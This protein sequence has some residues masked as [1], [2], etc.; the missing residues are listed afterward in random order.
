MIQAIILSVMPLLD[1]MGTPAPIPMLVPMGTPAPMPS[2][3]GQGRPNEDLPTVGFDTL[4]HTMTFRSTA[5][6][7]YTCAIQIHLTDKN[8]GTDGTVCLKTDGSVEVT[9]NLNM[10]DAAKLFWDNVAHTMPACPA[11]AP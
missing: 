4:G 6:L 8:A 9:G 5:D 11:M 7:Q 3:I 2:L 10:N 1:P